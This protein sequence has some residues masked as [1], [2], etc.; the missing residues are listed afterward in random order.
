MGLGEGMVVLGPHGVVGIL[1][2]VYESTAKV[3]LLT[4][5]RSTWGA[6]VEGRGELGLLRGTGDPRVVELHFDRTATESVE[7]EIIV[8]SGMAG[9]IAPGGIPF[10]RVLSVKANRKGEPM[11]LVELPQEPA[12]LRT[13]FILPLERI[14]V[15]AIR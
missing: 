7:E 3:L 14:S 15:E 13:L 2:G 12:R 8:T 6:Q 4:D 11:A 10:G 1:E 9:S 5:S